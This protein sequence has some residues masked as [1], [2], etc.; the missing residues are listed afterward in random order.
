MVGAMMLTM[1]DI[2][3]VAAGALLM[4]PLDGARCD[5]AMRHIR[6]TT[7]AGLACNCIIFVLNEWNGQTDDDDTFTSTR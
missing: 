5:R 1:V 3:G 2:V 7:S 4:L 6:R